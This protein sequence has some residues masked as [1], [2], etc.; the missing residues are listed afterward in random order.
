[1]GKQAEAASPKGKG[2]KGSKPTDKTKNGKTRAP[3]PPAPPSP[4][5]RPAPRRAGGGQGGG[6]VSNAAQDA[7]PSSAT[8]GKLP[9][10]MVVNEATVTQPINLYR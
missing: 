10:R 5:A 3:D 7:V 6:Q 1:M 9:E 4:P 2:P 8:R